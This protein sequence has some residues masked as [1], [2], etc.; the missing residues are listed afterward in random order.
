MNQPSEMFLKMCDLCSPALLT[1]S[2]GQRTVQE[3]ITGRPMSVCT[4][5]TWVPNTMLAK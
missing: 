3:M 1:G 5:L 4:D 2:E